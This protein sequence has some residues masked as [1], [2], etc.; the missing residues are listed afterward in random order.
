MT[1]ALHRLRP[2]ALAVVSLVLTACGPNDRLVQSTI[3]GANV[4]R[5]AGA[6]AA[7]GCGT[8]HTVGG[9]AGARGKVGPPLDGIANRSMIAGEAANTAEN[10]VRWIRNPQSIE[11]TTM[12]PDLGIDERTARDMAA[13]LYTRR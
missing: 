10:M 3:P 13:F 6:M 2:C 12:M 4:K 9:V 1:V 11:P 5:G 7:Y 8:C